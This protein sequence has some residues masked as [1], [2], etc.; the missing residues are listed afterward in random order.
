M[1][2]CTDDEAH[3]HPESAQASSSDQRQSPAGSLSDYNSSS[4]DG[5]LWQK[6]ID[7]KQQQQS[8]TGTWGF[9]TDPKQ[10]AAQPSSSASSHDTKDKQMLYIQME[11][12]PRTLKKTLVDGPI[13][14]GAAWQVIDSESLHTCNTVTKTLSRCILA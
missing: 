6:N 14:E 11:F 10:D 7:T 1:P 9:E 8:T 4:D 2:A 13:E 3:N 12:C 5:G